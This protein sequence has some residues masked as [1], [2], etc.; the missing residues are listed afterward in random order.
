MIFLPLQLAMR[1]AGQALEHAPAVAADP[2]AFVQLVHRQRAGDD[3]DVVGLIKRAGRAQAP[4]LV[5]GPG[6]DARGAAM[7][8]HLAG[9]LVE[10]DGHL[11]VLSLQRRSPVAALGA[12][13]M[14]YRQ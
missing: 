7:L 3:D 10:G 8:V 2:Q 6:L 4:A 9:V 14:S 12:S 5:H 11:S 13:R 1:Q